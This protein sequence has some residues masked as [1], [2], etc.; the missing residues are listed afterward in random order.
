MRRAFGTG[1]G[2]AMNEVAHSHCEES[3]GCGSDSSDDSG[4]KLEEI[5]V[6]HYGRCCTVEYSVEVDGDGAL[7]FCVA[8]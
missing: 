3:K 4:K 5:S 7:E 8:R 1:Q 2:C 6:L